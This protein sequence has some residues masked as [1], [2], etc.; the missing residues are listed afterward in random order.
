MARSAI[1]NFKGL[2]GDNSSFGLPDFIQYEPL[3]SRSKLHDWEI[4]EHLHAELFQL[5]ILH[6]GEGILTSEK[7]K[8]PLKGPCIV[9][10][11]ANIL[12]GFHFEPGITGEVFTFLESYLESIL[13]NNQSILHAFTAQKIIDFTSKTKLFELINTYK[14]HIIEELFEEES[15][16]KTSLQLLFQ[17][18]LIQIFR[19]D[20]S[21]E[22]T[23]LLTGNRTLKH[24]Q[25]FFKLVKKDLNRKRIEEYAQELGITTVHLN[26]VCQKIVQKTAVQIVNEYVIGDA[27]RYLLNTSYSISEISYFLNFNDPAYFTRLFKKVT[28]VSP[29]EFRKN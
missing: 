26:R 23:S 24:F 21:S 15:E 6:E 7:K 27:K 13:K 16:K 22:K 28:G 4:Q 2:Y 8:L 20:L 10:I 14:N 9:I 3:E 19:A 12:H 1:L 17:L 11:P 29:S 5:F 18:L 25:D